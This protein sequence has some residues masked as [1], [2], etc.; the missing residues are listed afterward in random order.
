MVEELRHDSV[1]DAKL[2]MAKSGGSKTLKD[3]NRWQIWLTIAANAVV[4]YGASQWDAIA[5]SGFRAAIAGA[6]NLLPVG[7]AVVVTTVANGLL[8]ADLKA[9]L[10]FLRWKHALPGH[11]AFSVYARKDPRIDFVRLQRALGNKPPAGPEAENAA[12]YRFYLEVQNVPAVQQVHRDFLL[13]RDY[14]G[15]AAL[16]LIGFGLAALFVVATWKVFAFYLGFL[17]LQLIVVRHAA[18]TYGIRFV[19]TVLAQKAGKATR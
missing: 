9:R 3:L 4:F 5:V 18:A 19:C 6:A 8:S 13:L 17:V 12:W 11:R 10:V 14:T 16:F 2:P 1:E 15:L 7:L